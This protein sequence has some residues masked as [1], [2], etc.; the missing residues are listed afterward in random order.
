MRLEDDEEKR[1]TKALTTCELLQDIK[2][3]PKVKCPYSPDI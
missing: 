2:D 3:S 1:A